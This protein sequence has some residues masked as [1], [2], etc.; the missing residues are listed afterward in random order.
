MPIFDDQNKHIADSLIVDG[1]LEKILFLDSSYHI[2]S[3]I[4]SRFQNGK[5]NSIET[6]YKGLP[7]FENIY[8]YKNGAI[9]RYKFYSSTC[10]DCFYE[11]FYDI[12]GTLKEKIGN[13]FFNSYVVNYENNI[14]NTVK[15]E[16]ITYRI[17][18]PTPPDCQS[19]ISLIG[20][21]NNL[22]DVFNTSFLK[23]LKVT[24]N[25][26]KFSGNY[27]TR[28]KLTIKESETKELNECINS[29][30]INVK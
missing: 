9:C 1:N 4:F 16:T 13:I 6:F 29:F 17:F 21:D 12:K 19:I 7:V 28:I 24:Y 25:D 18:F 8:F 5:T 23:Y 27:E 14:I 10:K 11:R 22:Y 26:N 15:G 3:I 30:F 20:K 2:D